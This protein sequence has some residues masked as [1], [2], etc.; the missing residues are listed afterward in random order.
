MRDTGGWDQ[1]GSSG[2][3]EKWSDSWIHSVGRTGFSDGVNV[4][5]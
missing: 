1:G 4:G 5:C 3:G 2:G